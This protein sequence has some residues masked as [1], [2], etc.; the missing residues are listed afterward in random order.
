MARGDRG[1]EKLLW[2][3]YMGMTEK[4]GSYGNFDRRGL[5]IVKR[6]YA[7]LFFFP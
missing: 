5:F 7:F 6:Y 4:L 1:Y 2:T 3:S